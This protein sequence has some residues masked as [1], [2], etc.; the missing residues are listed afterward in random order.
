[1]IHDALNRFANATAL[2]T[3]GTGRALVGDQIDLGAAQRDVGAGRQLYVVI[4]VTAAVTSAGAATVDFELVSDAAAAIAT[5]GTATVHGT[6]GAIGKASLV[7]G[8]EWVI[9]LPQEGNA[10]ERYLGLISNIG[11][12]ALTA[13]AVTAF[14]TDQPKQ[15]K[16]YPDGSN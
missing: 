16:T 6:T 11:T 10:Y 5:D 4:Q 2:S 1:M 12:A 14:L 13:G 8:A 3:S 15:H 9:P 7:A